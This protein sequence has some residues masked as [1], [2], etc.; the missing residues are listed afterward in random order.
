MF[1]GGWTS[2]RLRVCVSAASAVGAFCSGLV[3]GCFELGVVAGPGIWFFDFVLMPSWSWVRP[4]GSPHA[5]VGYFSDALLSLRAE[6][7]RGSEFSH[8]MPLQHSLLELTPIS[9]TGRPVA[10]KSSARFLVQIDLDNCSP[11]ETSTV[12]GDTQE[13]LHN[14]KIELAAELSLLSEKSPRELCHTVEWLDAIIVRSPPPDAP[15]V[16]RNGVKVWRL[17]D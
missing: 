6:Q 3:V 13:F 1:C 2:S 14:L 5:E 8:Y 11:K 7:L 12:F 9:H 10:D 15:L 4:L 17:V 16:N